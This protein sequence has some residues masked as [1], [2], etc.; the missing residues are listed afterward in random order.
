MNQGALGSTG[1]GILGRRI[2]SCKDLEVDSIQSIWRRV[3]FGLG[4]VAVL[5]IHFVLSAQ[6]GENAP[7]N[8]NWIMFLP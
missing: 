2:C 5:K 6:K 4:F 8:V 7:A 1:R 3:W